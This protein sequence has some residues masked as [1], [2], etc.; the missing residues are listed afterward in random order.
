MSAFDLI[1]DLYR[2]IGSVERSRYENWE[3]ATV[4]KP[5]YV[6]YL[7]GAFQYSEG[8]LTDR[9]KTQALIAIDISF[10]NVDAF[11]LDADAIPTILKSDG[12]NFADHLACEYGAPKPEIRRP[13]APEK[14]RLT[15][16]RPFEPQPYPLEPKLLPPRT[17]TLTDQILT[18]GLHRAYA[19]A[20]N[21]LD[22]LQRQ[23]SIKN[24]EKACAEIDAKNVKA[25]EIYLT[26]LRKLP[27]VQAYAAAFAAYEE[28]NSNLEAERDRAVE[29]WTIQK[30]LY[31]DLRL[32]DRNLI[33]SLTQRV[34][35]GDSEALATLCLI[36]INSTPYFLVVPRIFSLYADSER[37]VIF[38]EMHVPASHNVDFYRNKPSKS[39]VKQSPISKTERSSTYDFLVQSMLLR[40]MCDVSQMSS[41]LTEYESIAGNI[42]SRYKHPATGLDTESIIASVLVPIAEARAVDPKHVSPNETF[43]AWKG[44][45]AKALSDMIPVQPIISFDKNDSRLIEGREVLDLA[46]KEQNL[47]TMDWQDFEHLVRQVFELEFKT[48]GADV[49]VTQSSRDRGVDCIIYDPDPIRGGKIVV[50]AK[51]YTNTVDVS[52]VRDLFG[53]VQAEG[54]NRGVLVTTSKFGADSY[55]FAK[56]KPLTLLDGS[57]LLSLMQKHGYAFRIN[58]AQARNQ[59]FSP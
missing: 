17:S 47:A 39:G 13:A 1:P 12:L 16:V 46:D 55:E 38:L 7:A 28:C 22:E 6:T 21:R 40:A 5:L 30:Q 24:W 15:G 31:D 43:R 54:A 27:K 14:P 33:L 35:A 3:Y 2:P 37:R 29:E 53:T 48:T 36:Q 50:Q 58:L 51:R 42:I 4:Q 11:S 34:V 59:R 32:A 18:L 19:N 57:Q 41:T 10:S 20:R 56:N 9:D 44:V 52:S 26:E 8:F 25:K 45:S 23:R 49:R